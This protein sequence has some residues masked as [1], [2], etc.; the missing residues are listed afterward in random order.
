MESVEARNLGYDL[1]CRRAQVEMHVEVKGASG[2]RDQFLLTSNEYWTAISDPLYVVIMVEG[3]RTGGVRSSMWT[4]E[5]LKS[6]FD[7]E[8]I[9]FRVRPR[10]ANS[11][12]PADA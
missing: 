9:G 5:E 8:P 6:K 3:I 12:L 1:L 11:G 4:A 10:G 2:N 7:F